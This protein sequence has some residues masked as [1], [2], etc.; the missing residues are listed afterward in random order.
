MSQ[1]RLQA[2]CALLL[3]RPKVDRMIF[4]AIVL[5]GGRASR[6]GGVPKAELVVA[7]RTLLSRSLEATT[8]ARRTVVVGTA[9]DLHDKVLV[10]R[11]QPPFGGPAAAIGAGLAALGLVESGLDASG[12]IP[13]DDHVLVLACDVPNSALAVAALLAAQSGDRDGVIAIDDAGRRQPLLGLY[14]LGPLAVAVRTRGS[15]IRGLSVR[16]LL[17]PLDLAEVRVPEGSTDDIDT[18]ADA[19]VFGLLPPRTEYSPRQKDSP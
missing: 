14:R 4:D 1:R 15:G 11:E 13:F 19:A 3:T 16:D 18:W 2:E 9:V 10:T 7:G 5:A 12:A 8:G 17:S 6:L